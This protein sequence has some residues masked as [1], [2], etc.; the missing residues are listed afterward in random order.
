MPSV[1]SVNVLA[2][3]WAMRAGPSATIRTATVVPVSAGIAPSQVGASW[4]LTGS[5]RPSRISSAISVPSSRNV[6]G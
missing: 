1:R 2:S 6:T 5:G 3:I 4:R